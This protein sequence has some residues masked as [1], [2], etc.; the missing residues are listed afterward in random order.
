MKMIRQGDLLFIPTDAIPDCA[1]TIQKEGIVE[2]GESTGHAHKIAEPKSADVFVGPFQHGRT[3]ISAF[4]KTGDDGA[5]VIHEEHLAVRL[6]PKKVYEVHRARE[7][8]YLSD[9]SRFIAD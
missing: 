4:V 7:F 6:E 1:E 9:D 5:I 8:D 3:R 2:R